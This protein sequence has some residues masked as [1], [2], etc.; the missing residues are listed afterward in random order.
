LKTLSKS[1]NSMAYAIRAKIQEV[2]NKNTILNQEIVK[3][4]KMEAAL[5]K[6]YDELDQK[7]QMRTFEL[8]AVNDQLK[9]EITEKKRIEKQIKNS[10]DQFQSLVTNIPGITFRCQMDKDWTMMFMSRNVERISGYPATDFIDNSVRSYGSIIHPDDAEYVNLEVNK[11]INAGK[12]WEIEYRL[13]HKDESVR[14]VYEK[15]R[16]ISGS[17][18]TIEFLDGF[19]LDITE[20]KKTELLL[21]ESQE[22]YKTF[23]THASEGIYRIDIEPPILITLPKQDL[24]EKINQSAL[25]AEVNESL[26][27]MYGLAVSDMVGK[28]AIDFAPNYGERASLVV[29]SENYSVDNVETIDVD[30]DG[31]TVFLLE[32]Y[33]GEIIDNKLQRIWGVQRNITE[34]KLFED[35]L[36]RSSELYSDL[37]NNKLMG[38]YRIRVF[39]QRNYDYKAWGDSEMPPFAFEF[40]NDKFCEIFNL[41]RQELEKKPGF[42]TDFVYEKDKAEWININ[43][44][45][46]RKHSPF[47]WEGRFF[48]EDKI[49]WLY[50]ESLP[51]QLSS[52]DTVWTGICF[53]ITDK[54]KRPSEN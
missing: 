1:I 45:A 8:N 53:D 43:L 36:A 47:K 14:W 37:A 5:Q 52:G 32:S 15:G 19:I 54:K 30:K 13:N 44:E 24:I 4:V 12:S 38:T 16:G 2:K 27:G 10:R 34:R 46:N 17:D 31:Q 42:I 50:L 51:R 3:R 22:Q 33:H 41:S 7:V 28:P 40:I 9:Q 11:A 49:C 21:S 20:K 23:I 18:R 25:I 39:F 48:I 29:E 26:S 35:E 6:A